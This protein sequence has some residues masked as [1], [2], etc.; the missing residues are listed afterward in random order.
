MFRC[1]WRDL[2][3][4]IIL[5]STSTSWCDWLGMC[6]RLVHFWLRILGM[7]MWKHGQELTPCIH[8][9]P[10]FMQ[11][12]QAVWWM[13]ISISF[14]FW[15]VICTPSLSRDT[16][17]EKVPCSVVG[18]WATN[19]KGGKLTYRTIALTPLI[20]CAWM[21]PY[22]Q[23]FQERVCTCLTPL[24]KPFQMSDEWLG[25]AHPFQRYRDGVERFD[26]WSV[27]WEWLRMTL[28][29]DF[30]L[31]KY[32]DERWFELVWALRWWRYE[33]KRRRK[34]TSSHRTKFGDLS[35]FQIAAGSSF[36]SRLPPTHWAMQYPWGIH[37][38]IVSGCVSLA[39]VV[40][41][42]WYQLAR[43]CIHR[44]STRSRHITK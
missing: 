35:G 9:C 37:G 5:Y 20:K 14:T 44:S 13:G 7:G 4:F 25:V 18:F 34:R 1:K 40:L 16:W 28:T 36:S 12:G 3:R 2:F 27:S 33:R 24:E 22:T 8:M 39:V 32:E 11:M 19:G 41:T 30:S 15:N 42:Y 43:E 29:N 21:S 31:G 23:S 10:K 38:W 26:E 6:V 17:G